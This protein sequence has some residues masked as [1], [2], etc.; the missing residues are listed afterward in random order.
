MDPVMRTGDQHTA[1][2]HIVVMAVGS[3]SSDNW[4]EG[5]KSKDVSKQDCYEDS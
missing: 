5:I 4:E 2:A 1:R 3:L